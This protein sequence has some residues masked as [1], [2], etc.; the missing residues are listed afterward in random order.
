MR[1]LRLFFGVSL[2]NFSSAGTEKAKVLPE[3]V[4]AIPTMSE[5]AIITGQHW[6][7]MG[8][9][10][11]NFLDAKRA[12]ISDLMGAESK[13]KKGS[14]GTDLLVSLVFT[15]ILLAVRQVTR[16]EGGPAGGGEED[17]GVL[18]FCGG[19]E[20]GQRGTKGMR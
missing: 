4:S 13:E 17:G 9:G 14:V 2:F 19:G 3:P 8:E 7:W 10:F 20:R 12:L 1:G 18:D 15:T 16:S 5:P 6:A 11:T